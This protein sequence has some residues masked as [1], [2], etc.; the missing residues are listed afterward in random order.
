MKNKQEFV[1]QSFRQSCEV[2]M[3]VAGKDTET[4]IRMADLITDAFRSGGK[5]LICGNGGSASDSQHIATEF[6]IRYRGSFDRPALPAIA[7]TT[8]SSAMTAG[9]NDIGFENTF[10]RM[11]EALGRPGDVLLG[12]STSG[13]SENVI[14]AMVYA[15]AHGMK[16]IGL[17]GG[18]GGKMPPLC[19]ESVIVPWNGS[20]HV[21]ETHI[22]IG[23]IIVQ[24]VEETLYS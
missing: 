5:L 4:I 20:N 11:V 15:R 14:R 13:N 22:T 23:H 7:L 17:L 10:Q 3:Q 24:M 19:D 16:V 1:Q 12:L 9:P 8:D 21:Q 6:T 2:K 18:N